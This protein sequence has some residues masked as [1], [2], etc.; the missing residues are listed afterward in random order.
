MPE[1]T[2]DRVEV[3]GSEQPEG[4]RVLTPEALDFA[5][6]LH[7]EFDGRRSDLLSRRE[8][9]QARIRGGARPDFLE[10]T[11]SVR[12]GSWRVAE[13]PADLRERVVE[14]TGPVDRKMM[15]NA[16]NSGADVFM[17]DFED[18]LSP[19]WAN[20]VAGQANCMDAVRGPQHDLR[21]E[22]DDLGDDRIDGIGA[23]RLRGR[24]ARQASVFRL[25]RH[26]VWAWL[27]RRF[28]M[29]AEGFEPPTFW[30]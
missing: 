3:R 16:L 9:R 27:S 1:M 2:L 24:Q 7:A 14:I 6:R 10:E 19:T 30:V 8:A 21:G 18:A 12:E 17:A 26:R 20:V 22:S 25:F 23:I 28:R 11:R 29:G 15:I 13:A 4:A 5:S